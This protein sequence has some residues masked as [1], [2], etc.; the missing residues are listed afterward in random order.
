M[1]LIGHEEGQ[2]AMELKLAG[3]YGSNKITPTVS[4]KLLLRA[5]ICCN[6]GSGAE[7]STFLMEPIHLC[8]LF[9]PQLCFLCAGVF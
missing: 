1:R 7:A 8:A 9:S 6:L 3:I 4:Q 2:S 5:S